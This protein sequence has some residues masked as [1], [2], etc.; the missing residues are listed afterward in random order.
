MKKLLLFVFFVY[1]VGTFA[2]Q[3]GYERFMRMHRMRM[4]HPPVTAQS[5]RD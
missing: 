1:A 4:H 3:N 5:D 2:Q